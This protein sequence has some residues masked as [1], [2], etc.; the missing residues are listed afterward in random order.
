MFV[1]VLTSV[2]ILL[3]DLNGAECTMATPSAENL[4]PSGPSAAS[5]VIKMR[6]HVLRKGHQWQ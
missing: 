3:N 4:D 2:T 1:K 5:D 6:C